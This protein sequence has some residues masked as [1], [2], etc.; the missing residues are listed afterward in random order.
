ME[1]T[2]IDLAAVLLIVSVIVALIVLK[3]LGDRSVK[4]TENS[5]GL[6]NESKLTSVNSGDRNSN[7]KKQR[8]KKI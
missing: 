5:I 2:A 6:V 7:L 4:E 3:Y 8:N 1:F